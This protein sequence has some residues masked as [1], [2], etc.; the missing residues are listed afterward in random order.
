MNSR[1]QVT[2]NTGRGNALVPN[3]AGRAAVSSQTTRKA[4]PDDRRA[5]LA[6]DPDRAALPPK[7]H[8]STLTSGRQRP[9]Q[10]PGALP[11]HGGPYSLASS[12]SSNGAPTFSK[13]FE[14][15]PHR[16]VRG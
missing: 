1:Q 11:N 7:L 3:L 8:S 4:C 15:T 14:G 9:Q 2:D 16:H 5:A 6:A 10:R 13:R 12:P